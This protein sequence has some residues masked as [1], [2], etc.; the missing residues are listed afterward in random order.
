MWRPQE[1]GEED[2]E[3]DMSL[4]RGVDHAHEDLLGDDFL[5]LF[6]SFVSGL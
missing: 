2:V 1:D 3:V 5:T 4:T 6:P